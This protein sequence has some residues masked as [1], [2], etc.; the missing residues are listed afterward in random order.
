MTTQQKIL[1][2]LKSGDK[3]AFKE[4]FERFFKPLCAFGN[5]YIADPNEVED[6][7]QEVFVS[8][9]ERRNNFDHVNALKTFL[10]TSVRN[11]CLNHLKHQK[12]RHKHEYS[13]IY[14]LESDHIFTHHVIEEESFNQLYIEI[15]HLPKSSQKIMLL[16]LK[17]L[18]NKEIAAALSVSENTVKTQKK[19]AYRKLKKKL[20]PNLNAILLSL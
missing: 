8:F 2:E 16:A 12:V 10:Y 20:S 4:I 5:R 18:K 13:L 15:N 6:L 9:W 11:S 14:E 1:E 7:V 17:G 19:I 3:N